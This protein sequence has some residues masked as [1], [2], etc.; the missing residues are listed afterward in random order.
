MKIAVFTPRSVGIGIA[1][2]VLVAAG[3]GQLTGAAWGLAVLNGLAAGALALSIVVRDGRFNMMDMMDNRCHPGVWL[4]AYVV[5]ITPV[6]FVDDAIGIELS[7]RA[8]LFALSVLFALT[9]FASYLLGGI[10]GTLNQLDGDA[11][12]A[13]PRLHRV[14][15]GPASTTPR[16]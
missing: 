15:P 2:G 7:D 8:N 12:G 13:D 3:L 16:S 4:L 11:V 10:M 1:G 5:M 6:L 14:T 9:G